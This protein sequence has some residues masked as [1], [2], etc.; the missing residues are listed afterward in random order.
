MTELVGTGQNQAAETITLPLSC[1]ETAGISFHLFVN[2]FPPH[3]F[4]FLSALTDI[5][6]DIAIGDTVS[7]FMQ[8][9]AK[10][11]PKT[12]LVQ[13]ISK[14]ILFGRKLL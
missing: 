11:Q 8:C 10:T 12:T 9:L 1:C 4:L 5:E 14:S 6:A 2:W 7:L 3:L 13:M